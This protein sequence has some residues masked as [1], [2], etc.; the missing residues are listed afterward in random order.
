MTT[1]DVQ[2]VDHTKIMGAAALLAGAMVGAGLLALPTKTFTAGF[3]PSA[4]SLAMMALYLT[5]TSILIL[6][7]SFEHSSSTGARGANVLTLCKHSLGLKGRNTAW[8]LY[9]FIYYPTITAYIAEGG[10]MTSLVVAGPRTSPVV[11]QC[12]FAGLFAIIVLQGAALVDIVNRYAITAAV[13]TFVVLVFT[14]ASEITT[15][16]LLRREWGDASSMLSIMFARTSRFILFRNVL[17]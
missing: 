13:I 4:L 14:G 2:N 1:T 15:E 9:V 11:A 8:A 12:I 16:N 17:R 3:I 5:A 10:R 6:E 7:L